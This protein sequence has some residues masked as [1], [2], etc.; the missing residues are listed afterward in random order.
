MAQPNILQFPEK[1][2]QSIIL[3][4]PEMARR[5]LAR[6]TRNRPIRESHVRRLM[7]EMQSGRWQYNGEAIK[8]S[9]DDVLLDGQHR[10]TALSRMPD[11]FPA[12]P[13]LVV[14][15]LPT[16]AQ[17]TMDQGRMREA[18]D[19]LVIDG[20]AGHNSKII[21]SAIRVYVP[22]RTGLLFKDNKAQAL[23][24]PQVTRWAYDHPI[25]MSMLND[26]ATAQLRRV[27]VRPSI[28]LAVMLTLRQVDGE[29][30]RQFA[31]AL[32][33]GAG[34]EIGNPILTLRDR[35][36]R[37]KETKVQETDREHIG[38]FITTWNAWRDGRSLRKLQ[39]PKSG[40]WTADTFPEPK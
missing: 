4:T 35:L 20:L 40:T 8:W 23:S 27:K 33:S 36:D 9:V 1:P 2:S 32:Y 31:E 34:L 39:R 19:Q 7:D 25:E 14:R 13:F 17:N 16:S 12:I 21:A 26:L 29:A 22:W 28:T 24:N 15:G 18:S 37:L 5:V 6:N 11:T 3:V 38:F 10:L 30:Q